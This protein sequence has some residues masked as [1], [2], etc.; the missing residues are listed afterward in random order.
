M[1][2]SIINL[3]YINKD[4]A[5]PIVIQ[6]CLSL[7]DLAIL[8]DEWDNPIQEICELFEK[9]SNMISVLFQFL[10]YVPEE[11]NNKQLKLGVNI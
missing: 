3:L 2:N 1:K 4:N 8:C 7:A 10:A 5:N 6:L 9:G 11:L